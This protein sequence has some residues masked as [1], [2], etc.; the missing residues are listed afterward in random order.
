MTFYFHVSSWLYKV[1]STN[2]KVPHCEA[3]SYP[4]FHRDICL[5]ISFTNNCRTFPHP[6][7]TVATHKWH[8]GYNYSYHWVQN[9]Y[10]LFRKSWFDA[11]LLLFFTSPLPTLT[12]TIAKGSTFTI[13]S[14]FDVTKLQKKL[15]WWL[16]DW[17]LSI[18]NVNRHVYSYPLPPL[19]WWGKWGR[20]RVSYTFPMSSSFDATKLLKIVLMS[21]FHSQCQCTRIFISL[22]TL[23][24]MGTQLG[25]K[26]HSS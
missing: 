19:W 18:P 7:F 23:M 24:A 8:L 4:H 10:Q 25:C 20:W 16:I 2:Y 14:P 1:N 17:Q 9:S 22:T 15:S 3:F 12:H 11:I 21:A 5:R 13:S 26:Q 6:T